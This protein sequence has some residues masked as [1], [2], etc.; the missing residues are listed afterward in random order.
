MDIKDVKSLEDI[1]EFWGRLGSTGS[2]AEQ[3]QTARRFPATG[4]SR[5]SAAATSS[6]PV[7]LAPVTNAVLPVNRIAGV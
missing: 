5:C 6:F 4:L 1:K 7:P 3:L 2:P